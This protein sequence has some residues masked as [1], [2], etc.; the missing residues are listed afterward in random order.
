MSFFSPGQVSG[1]AI[2]LWNVGP[3]SSSG[4][5]QSQNGNGGSVNFGQL[6]LDGLNNVNNLQ[7]QHQNLVLKSVTDP[8]N[9][10]AHDIMIA[11]AEAN[12]ALNITKN[13]VDRVIQAYKSIITV[14]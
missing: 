9:V 11:Q 3:Q 5:G 2:N 13:V 8:Q 7:Q 1:Q 10:N 14:R 6:L 4:A 12:M